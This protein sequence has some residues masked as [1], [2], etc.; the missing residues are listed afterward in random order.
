MPPSPIHWLHH[1]LKPR[2]YINVNILTHAKCQLGMF[3]DPLMKPISVLFSFVFKLCCTAERGRLWPD[4]DLCCLIHTCSIC[5]VRVCLCCRSSVALFS[6]VLVFDVSNTWLL[7]LLGLCGENE[8]FNESMNQSIIHSF[9]SEKQQFVA[10]QRFKSPTG[11][12]RFDSSSGWFNY[13]TLIAWSRMSIVFLCLTRRPLCQSYNMWRCWRC[14][15]DAGCFSL[16]ELCYFATVVTSM[17]TST[18]HHHLSK[19]HWLPAVRHRCEW[20]WR[21]CKSCREMHADL[22]C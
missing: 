12:W 16:R 2:M 4:I 22:H 5:C 14:L 17:A 3:V 1:S 20:Q 21:T 10:T 13:F 6:C 19:R 15:T 9:S 7:L 11:K 18:H 8:W